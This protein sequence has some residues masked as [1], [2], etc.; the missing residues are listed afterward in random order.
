MADA[1]TVTVPSVNAGGLNNWSYLT[2]LI[3][4]ARAA[5]SQPPLPQFTATTIRYLPDKDNGVDK[6]YMTT[7]PKSA[8]EGRVLSPDEPFEDS[9]FP[10]SGV[11]TRKWFV[12][13]DAG[14]AKLD[15]LMEY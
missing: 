15:I 13:S 14:A 2:D 12:K 10:G 4:A 8:A 9:G 1:T 11:S 7:D 6:I 3:I 5:A